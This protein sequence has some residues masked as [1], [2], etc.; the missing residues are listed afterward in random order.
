MA[1]SLDTY[2]GYDPS[3][4][5]IL[6]DTE[7]SINSEFLAEEIIHAIQHQVFYGDAMD[8][9]YKNFEFEAKVFHDFAYNKALLYDNLDVAFWLLAIVTYP[10]PTFESEYREW[11]D[12]C[13]KKDVCQVLNLLHTTTFVNNGRAI[14]ENTRKLWF[15][16]F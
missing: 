6:F 15:L 14:Q 10:D 5:S 8:M 4:C 3:D 9:K 7:S 13:A 16:S 2:A 11:L 12:K 1:P